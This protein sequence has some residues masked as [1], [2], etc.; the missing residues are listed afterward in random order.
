MRTFVL[1]KLM[2]TAVRNSATHALPVVLIAAIFFTFFLTYRG[3][4]ERGHDSDSVASNVF[5]AVCA[6]LS[7]EKYHTGRYVCA[8]AVYRQMA[9]AGLGFWDMGFWDKSWDDIGRNKEFINSRLETLFQSPGEVQNDGIT[10]IGWAMDAG[11]MD[12]VE[13][14]VAVFGHKLESLYSMFFLLLG[15]STALACIQFYDRLFALFA[16][17]SFQVVLFK[18][19]PEVGM[20]LLHSFT[21]VQ[22]LSILAITPLLHILF[23]I[24]YRVR[25]STRAIVLCIPQAA[26]MVLVAEFRATTYWTLVALALICGSIISIAYW[27]VR[28]SY[29][30]ELARCWPVLP[31]IVSLIATGSFVAATVDP[32]LAAIGGMKMHAF[33]QPI[34]YN[35]QLHPEWQ[36]KYLAQHEGASGDRTTEVAVDAYRKRHPDLLKEPLTQRSYEEQTRLVLFEFIRN[37]PWYF[38]ELKYINAVTMIQEVSNFVLRILKSLPWPILML[39]VCGAAA[40]VSRIAIA[41]ENLETMTWSTTTMVALVPIVAAPAWITVMMPYAIAD[42]AIVAGTAAL[43]AGFGGMVVCGVLVARAAGLLRSPAVDPR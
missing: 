40:L 28:C 2:G 23:L 42:T 4:I 37:D 21:N 14:A 31:V 16:F 33:W 1:P 6:V 17:L 10:P 29:R 8:N 30:D 32:R 12:F 7:V 36:N 38:I 18:F 35:L 39:A 27:H 41:A 24:L 13:L 43:V 5:L 9:D 22:F 11:V 34:Y 19:L 25:P 15:I 3:G 26:L 20:W